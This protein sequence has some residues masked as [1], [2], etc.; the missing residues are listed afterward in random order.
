MAT[1][2]QL[3]AGLETALNT[4]SGLSVYS[5]EPGS[6]T[7][8]AAVV[9]TP[10]I[11]YHTS[12]NSAQALKNYQFRIMVLVAE[13]LVAEAAHTLD[14]YADPVAATSVRAA[15]E[16]DPTL[17]GVAESLIVESFRP[18]SAEEVASLTYWGGEF[19][20]TVYAR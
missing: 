13:G 2:A 10:S 17:G 20:V 14:T 6:I 15:I 16:A 1:I 3:R 11:T 9:V 8:P 4:I 12:F 18:L 7:P 5:A 19:T